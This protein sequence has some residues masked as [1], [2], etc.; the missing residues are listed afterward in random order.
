MHGTAE[1]TDIEEGMVNWPIISV[2]SLFQG[3]TEATDIDTANAGSEL[4]YIKSWFQAIAEATDTANA[5]S[6]LTYI[7]LLFQGIAETTDTEYEKWT[8][9]QGHCCKT[10]TLQIRAVNWRILRCYS[11]PLLK[12]LTLNTG[13]ELTYIKLLFQAIAETTDIEYGKWTNVC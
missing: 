9:V 11:R 1:V 6:E 13:S 2:L 4:T 7:K 10:L 5:G 8:D 12:R 3:I